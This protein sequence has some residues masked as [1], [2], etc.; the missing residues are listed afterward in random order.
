MD[1]RA[2]YGHGVPFSH[3][4]GRIPGLLSG[5]FVQLAEYPLCP[6]LVNV[7]LKEI[8]RQGIAQINAVFRVVMGDLHH[9]KGILY[10]KGIAEAVAGIVMG[11]QKVKGNVVFLTI[12]LE[13]THPPAGTRGRSAHSK[14]GVYIFYGSGRRGVQLKIVLLLSVEEDRKIRLVPYFKIPAFHFL[15]SVSLQQKADEFFDQIAPARHVLRHIDVIAVAEADFFPFRNGAG[16]EGQLHKG[17]HAALQH[18]VKYVGD[19][20]EAQLLNLPGPWHGREVKVVRQPLDHQQIIVKNSMEANIADPQLIMR[21]LD[22]LADVRTEHLAGVVVADAKL[23]G[24]IGRNG[25]SVSVDLYFHGITPFSA[26]RTDGAAVFR[27]WHNRKAP[28][29]S[30]LLQRPLPWSANGEGNHTG[31]R[32]CRPEGAFL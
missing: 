28:Q 3:E 18:I 5:R 32:Y 24:I 30:A 23:P 9:L 13:R 29:S 7:R 20:P 6:R 26:F 12:G 10:A 4:Q 22:V 8:L 1:R 27:R 16:H 11:R 15:F 19:L 31:Q 17:L 25:F 14:R 21:Q 2:V